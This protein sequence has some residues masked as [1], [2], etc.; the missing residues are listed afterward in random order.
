MNNKN[1]RTQHAKRDFNRKNKK[2]SMHNKQSKDEREE[3]SNTIRLQ[4]F[5]SHAGICSRRAA[6]PLL[7][8]E[9]VQVNKKI[10]T[11]PGFRVKPDIDVVSVHNQIYKMKQ[12][13]EFFM[14]NKPRKVESTNKSHTYDPYSDDNRRTVKDIML[15]YFDGYI[16]SVGRLDYHSSGLLVFTTDGT[17]CNQLT[18]PRYGVEKTYEL[19]TTHEFPEKILLKWLHGIKSE[20]KSQT[21]TLR[22]YK[23]I[24]PTKVELILQEGKNREI[25]NVCDKFGLIVKR[26]HRTKIG[27]LYL[28]K[29][30]SWKSEEINPT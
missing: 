12:K 26:L 6:I 22:K 23:I 10:V 13:F 17:L 21:Y 28:G 15:K 11:N 25:R 7:E 3:D 20:D 30:P 24:T 27:N 18:H 1:S 4:V 19:E 5:L 14:M 9:A 16:Y 8:S 29:L 2:D